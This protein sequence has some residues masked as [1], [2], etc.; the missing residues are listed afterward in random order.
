MIMKQ[1]LTTF[2]KWTTLN[3]SAEY[4]ITHK[5]EDLRQ[6]AELGLIDISEIK[7][8]LRK[9]NANTLLETLPEVKEL[10][11][12]PEYKKLQ[13]LGLELVSSRT[14]LLNGTLVFGQ[15]GYSRKDQFAIGLFQ[16]KVIK[17]MTPK[18]VPRGIW[19]RKIGEMD[20]NI[21]SFKQVP[22][23]D[24]YKIALD[25]IINYI[26]FDKLDSRSNTPYYPV[27]TRT[28]KTWLANR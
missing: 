1:Y 13:E 21:K 15:P 22:D 18:G 14:Q 24:F 12:T 28:P 3:E 4:S 16:N 11:A 2:S 7:K 9:H 10:L 20:V 5:L 27:K 23:Q 26:D 6:L 19:M 25:W 8:E 17:R